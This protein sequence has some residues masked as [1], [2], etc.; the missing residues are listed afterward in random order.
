MAV[1]AELK[2]IARNPERIH[3]ALS[4]RAVGEHST[5]TDRY[6]DYPDR[7]WTRQGTELRVRT[8][9]DEL[10]PTQTRA[11]LTF[12]EPAVDQAS[13]SKPEHETAIGDADVLTTVLTALGVEQIIAFEKHCV[14]YRFIAQGRDLLATVVTVPELAGQ[15]FIELETIAD[16]DDV[17][18]ALDLVRSVLRELGIDDSDLTTQAYTDA[19]AAR[20]GAVQ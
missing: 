19:I 3:A 13:G 5:Y 8:I 10:G 1:E 11:L 14:N 7:D 16:P 9:T 17:D 6:F 4:Q 2:A 12:K 20:R 18:T 15:T